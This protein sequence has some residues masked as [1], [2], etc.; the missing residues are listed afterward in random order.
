MRRHG[1]RRCLVLVALA[2]AV[3]LMPLACKRAALDPAEQA[4]IEA[5]V[6][7]YYAAKDNEA[8]ATV[9]KID[10]TAPDEVRVT[11]RLKYPSFHSVATTR[12]LIAKKQ[13][14]TWAVVREVGK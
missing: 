14:S 3:M 10:L 6:K 2:A 7:A 11:I 4:A 13:D 1:N 8:Q 9:H 5:A 12:T